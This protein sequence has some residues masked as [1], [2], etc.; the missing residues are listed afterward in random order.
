MYI[1][2]KFWLRHFVSITLI[3]LV[4]T[5]GLCAAYLRVVEVPRITVEWEGKS[6]FE[7]LPRYVADGGAEL[8]L[9][10]VGA[11]GCSASN[12]EDLPGVVDRIKMSVM[13]KAATHSR[14]FVAV[15]VSQDW[16]VTD[17]VEHLSKFGEFD[18][19]MTGRSWINAGIV[20][21]VW[22]NAFGEP[23]TPQIIIVD[24]ITRVPSSEDSRFRVVDE[25]LVIRKVGIGAIRQWL[26]AGTPLPDV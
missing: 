26:E 10:Y 7:Y 23:A 4:F 21:Y 2:K 24:R 9:I 18:E 8:A 14:N 11:S 19:I 3:V 20:K 25:N 12:D 13:D 6:N 15:G 22:E 17:G 5:L 16:S 1:A